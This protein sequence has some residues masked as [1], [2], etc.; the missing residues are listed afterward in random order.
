MSARFPNCSFSAPPEHD[1]DASFPTPE[2]TVSFNREFQGDGSQTPFPNAQGELPVFREFS[3][4]VSGSAQAPPAGV[5]GFA[6]PA[7]VRLT[8]RVSFNLPSSPSL[9]DPASEEGWRFG[10]VLSYGCGLSLAFSLSFM[11]ITRIS[12]S[13]FSTSRSALRVWCFSSGS[14]PRD[15]SHSR[16]CLSVTASPA[17][18]SG[19]SR[20]GGGGGGGCTA[21]ESPSGVPAF[22]DFCCLHSVLLLV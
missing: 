6:Q 1:Q 16:F 21:S 22:Y 14:T 9:V 13:F 3:M 7:V 2:S 19:P 11:P 4:L 17:S 20:S 5:V 10:S 15:K 18:S 12:S 8:A